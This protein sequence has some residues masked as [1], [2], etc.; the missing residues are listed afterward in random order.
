M[1]VGFVVLQIFWGVGRGAGREGDT[2]RMV[3][4]IIVLSSKQKVRNKQLFFIYSQNR[5]VHM[6]MLAS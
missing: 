4:A 1:F 6:Y 5:C 2:F 3:H